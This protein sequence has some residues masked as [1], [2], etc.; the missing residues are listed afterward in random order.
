MFL[1][2]CFVVVDPLPPLPANLIAVRDKLCSQKYFGG[3]FSVERIEE[4]RTSRASHVYS[5]SLEN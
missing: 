1:V 2:F 5:C 3:Y 4:V